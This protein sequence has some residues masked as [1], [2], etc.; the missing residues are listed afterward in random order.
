MPRSSVPRHA[1]TYKI[2]EPSL[3]SDDFDALGSFSRPN[4]LEN[5]NLFRS[6]VRFRTAVPETP[7]RVMPMAYA[8]PETLQHPI[9]SLGIDV[10]AVPAIPALGLHHLTL[11]PQ[12]CGPLS[13][14]ML[15]LEKEPWYRAWHDAVHRAVAA[16]IT[17]AR[18]G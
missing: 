12:Y 15:K 16:H 8:L 7:P 10:G 13:A 3:W 14:A 6:R 9:P 17:L 5:P 11:P 2:D 1:Q 18:A 4:N